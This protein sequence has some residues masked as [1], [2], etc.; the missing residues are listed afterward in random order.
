MVGGKGI[1][2]DKAGERRVGVACVMEY[3]AAMREWEAALVRTVDGPPL[4]QSQ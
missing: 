1:W 4:K 2:R 3:N